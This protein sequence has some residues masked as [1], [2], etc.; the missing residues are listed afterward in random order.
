MS[1]LLLG[2]VHHNYN[3]INNNNNNN[4]I[5][6]NNSSSG[7]SS[8]NNNTTTN[9]NS[10]CYTYNVVNQKTRRPKYRH[11]TRWI[12]AASSSNTTNLD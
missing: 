9:T 4:N 3:N 6:H 12:I 2:Y 1:A 7:G 5:H 10:K 11:C 8:N